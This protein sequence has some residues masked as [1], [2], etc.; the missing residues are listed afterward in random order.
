MRF[1]SQAGFEVLSKEKPFDELIRSH[2]PLGWDKEIDVQRLAVLDAS[3]VAPS[4]ADLVHEGHVG[5]LR[6]GFVVG[7]ASPRYDIT[8]ILLTGELSALWTVIWRTV[9]W[10]EVDEGRRTS[11]LATP[12]TAAGALRGGRHAVF[13]LRWALA[14]IYP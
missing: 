9:E 5:G 3:A 11:R 4:N 1:G 6:F 8:A 7:H 12:H 2:I 13:R 14:S 10:A